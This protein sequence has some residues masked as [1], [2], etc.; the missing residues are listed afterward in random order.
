MEGIEPGVLKDKARAAAHNSFSPHS[1]Y[2]VGAVVL[3]AGGQYF[4]GCNMESS[5]YGLTVCAERNALA[6]AIVTGERRFLAIGVYSPNGAT[7]CGA[8]RQIIWD[9]CGA[10]PVYIFSDEEHFRILN[11][12]ELLPEPFDNRILKEYRHS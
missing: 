7:P 10:I 2:P 12:G 11:S 5:S 6:A 4:T 1:G 9:I 8:C 3:T